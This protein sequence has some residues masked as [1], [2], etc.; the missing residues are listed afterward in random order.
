MSW[1]AEHLEVRIALLSSISYP[2]CCPIDSL[3]LPSFDLCPGD[4]GVPS[5]QIESDS[6]YIRG[7]RDLKS[8]SKQSSCSRKEHGERRH[9]AALVPLLLGS[10]RTSTK[11]RGRHPRPPTTWP[12][13]PC[14]TTVHR[15]RRTFSRPLQAINA[16]RPFCLACVHCGR[17]NRP[18]KWKAFATR[19][20]PLTPPPFANSLFRW[21]L[22][23]TTAFAPSHLDFL[24]HANLFYLVVDSATAF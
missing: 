17:R 20:L 23:S 14:C 21:F 22:G 15:R 3:A 9:L 18:L 4:I 13:T 5:G 2:H 12:G 7:N 6:A 8:T 24:V 11:K 16:T 1:N 10:F 19:W